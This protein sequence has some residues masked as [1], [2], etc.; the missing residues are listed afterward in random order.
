MKRSALAPRTTPIRSFKAYST[1]NMMQVETP[2]VYNG[3]RSYIRFAVLACCNQTLSNT[4]ARRTCSAAFW[5]WGP[6]C[7][8]CICNACQ[9]SFSMLQ[10]LQASCIL[11]HNPTWL[12]SWL[13]S[14]MFHG[15]RRQSAWSS[16]HTLTMCTVK[17]PCTRPHSCCKTSRMQ[18]HTGARCRTVPGQ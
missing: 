2:S 12:F 16:R 5:V 9:R 6:Y 14:W 4:D 10:P 17:C 3:P 7:C 11:P 15:R 13:F 18:S 8:T 1:T